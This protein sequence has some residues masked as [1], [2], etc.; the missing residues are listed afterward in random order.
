MEEPGRASGRGHTG[1]L[2]LLDFAVELLKGEGEGRREGGK[3][4]GKREGGD[5]EGGKG[6]K[7]GWRGE[8]DTD[9]K[10]PDRSR[11]GCLN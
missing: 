9:A 11:A 2:C 6:G 1:H 7:E 4:G 5:N 10:S 3:E 8:G